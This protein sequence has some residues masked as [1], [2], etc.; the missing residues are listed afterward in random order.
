MPVVAAVVEQTV[1][2]SCSGPGAVVAGKRSSAAGLGAPARNVVGSSEMPSCLI[3]G[4]GRLL[5]RTTQMDDDRGLAPL[6]GLD[7]TVESVCW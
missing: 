5:Y 6:I 7:G 1:S 4:P 3:S 2:L